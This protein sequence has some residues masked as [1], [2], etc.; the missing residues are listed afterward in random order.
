MV[1][2]ITRNVLEL[3][4]TRNIRPE[5]LAKDL[6]LGQRYFLNKRDD[7]S[8]KLLHKIGEYFDVSPEK[9]WSAEFTREIK[10]NHIE[11]EIARLEQ[12]KTDLEVDGFMP[13]PT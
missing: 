6:G 9:L 2:I 7:F 3:C 13:L 11:S 12:E 5:V 10:L 1:D 4:K 8:V